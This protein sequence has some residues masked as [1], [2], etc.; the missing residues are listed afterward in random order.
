MRGL[1]CHQIPLFLF[2]RK[3]VAAK[4]PEEE[5]TTEDHRP[6]E[7]LQTSICQICNK[8][9][10]SASSCWHRLNVNYVP[11]TTSSNNRAMVAAS[12]SATNNNWFLDSG[13]SAHLTNS[14]DNL[15]IASPYQGSDSI[16]IGDGR[17]MSI[18]NSGA[19]LLPTPAR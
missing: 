7:P 17:S 12:D 2:I 14:L 15:S 5:I 4:E 18:A 3:G 11:Q 1:V 6:Q 16:T 19:G 13:A 10:H 8:R 9:G